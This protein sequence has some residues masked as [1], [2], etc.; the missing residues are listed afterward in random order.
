MG[1]FEGKQIDYV[2]IASSKKFKELLSS[3]KKFI[4]PLTIFF[5]VFYFALPLLTSYSTVLNYKAVG[6]ISWAW[7]FAF[8]Q[9]IMTW[10]LC[11]VYVK[12][13]NLFDNLANEIVEEEFKKGEKGA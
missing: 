10:V 7:V 2:Q 3:K 11:T 9:F 1:K 4:V 13:A 6:D 5:L 12:K 8:A